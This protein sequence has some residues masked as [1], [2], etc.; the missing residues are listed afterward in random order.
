MERSFKEYWYEV[1]QYGYHI[2][3]YEPHRNVEKWQLYKNTYSAIKDMFRTSKSYKKLFDSIN[4]IS[5]GTDDNECTININGKTYNSGLEKFHLLVQLFRIPKLSG[6]NLPFVKT[7]QLA[8]NA[9]QLQANI[10]KGEYQMELVEFVKNNKLTE[11]TTYFDNNEKKIYAKLD[12]NDTYI[13]SI[14]FIYVLVIFLF[15]ILIYYIINSIKETF[16][17]IPHM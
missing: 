12:S 14:S 17:G 5:T 9:G 2:R 1:Y 16:N 7:L 3:N 10:D 11:V 15:L 6:F 13:N 8:Y 4:Y